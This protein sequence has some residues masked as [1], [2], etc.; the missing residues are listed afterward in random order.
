[1]ENR[2][3]KTVG[4]SFRK[5][6]SMQLLT[7][8]PVYVDD[9]TPG[10]ALVVMLLRSPHANAIV[11]EIRTDAAKKVP[12]VVDIYTWQDVPQT[13]FAIA[14]Q[15]YPEPSPYDRLILDRHVR[16]VGDAVAIIAAETEKAAR[17]A[18]K[19]IK[20]KYEVLEA[21]LDFRAAKD[22]PV[23]VHPEADW[24]P[25]CE[26]GGDNRRNLV[27]S[28]VSAHG[29]VDGIMADCD[30]VIDRTYHTKAFHQAMMEPYIC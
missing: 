17:K 22:N 26:V 4:K 5:K 2:E 23:L 11:Q 25:P 18:M 3:Y 19:L 20:V 24:F 14:G 15:T 30:I 7:G 10:N 16:F 29:D 8:K 1:M 12:G 27:A 6:D 13:R 9:V 28:E 21:V